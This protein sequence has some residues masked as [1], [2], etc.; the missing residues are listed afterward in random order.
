MTKAVNPSEDNNTTSAS[1]MARS[2]LEANLNEINK[3]Y[4]AA[5][6]LVVSL[7]FM[8]FGVGMNSWSTLS[9]AFQYHWSWEDDKV[10]LIN[11]MT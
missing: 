8:Q 6:C 9:P 11:D 4:I 1:M 10:T 2:G 5:N 7:G 3:G